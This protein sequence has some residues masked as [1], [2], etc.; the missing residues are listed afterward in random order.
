MKI[1]PIAASGMSPKH[2]VLSFFFAEL[3]AAWP[4][5]AP[6]AVALVALPPE[7]EVAVTLEGKALIVLFAGI[8]VAS[9]PADSELRA[10]E[11]MTCFTSTLKLSLQW[12]R[13]ASETWSS[14]Q[15]QVQVLHYKD[16]FIVRAHLTD[17]RP[18][19]ELKLCRTTLTFVICQSHS[20]IFNLLKIAI[21]SAF[22]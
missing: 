3:V 6:A 2:D 20:S 12:F 5:V 9:I 15:P 8:V 10:A 7:V 14:G 17:A 1:N 16:K 13:A 4:T 19:P 21:Y 22:R 11:I 18:H